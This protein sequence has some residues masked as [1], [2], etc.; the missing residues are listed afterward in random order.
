MNIWEW[1]LWILPF[2]LQSVV[3]AVDEGYF[4]KKRGVQTLEQVGH[5]L[6]TFTVLV[7]FLILIFLRPEGGNLKIYLFFVVL[8]CLSVTKDEWIHA[9]C[10]QPAEHWVHAVLFVLHPIVLGCAGML[11]WQ[12]SL[13]ANA[14]IGVQATLVGGIFLM[15]SLQAGL[16]WLQKV[17][18]G[19]KSGP[20]IEHACYSLLGDR[21]YTAF[22]DPVALLRAEAA[23]KNPW[24]HETM[25]RKLGTRSLQ[26]LDIGC[27]AGFL[28]N[29]LALW[30]NQ[31]TGVDLSESAL[32]VARKF[33]TTKTV[34]YRQ[35]DAYALPFEDQ[36]FDVVCAMDFLE[37]V[38][39]PDQVVAE[40]SRVL[41]PGG[42][43]FFHTFN[44]TWLSW[45]LAIQAVKWLVKNTPK[46]L[47][48][49]GLFIKPMELRKILLGAGLV[50]Q[51]VRGVKP[52][53]FK[54]S[55]LRSLFTRSVPVDF[56]FAFT[57]CQKVGYAGYA[58][59]QV[60]T[61]FN[62]SLGSV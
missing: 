22:D 62:Q 14:V 20:G 1:L 32:E 47:H 53:L 39:R 31:V 50:T 2:G 60:P 54:K 52:L 45:V 55:V 56:E 12:N 58:V 46:N 33:D 17:V 18:K 48:L 21:W 26:V 40:V 13:E 35:A 49:Y 28:S 11:W 10:C 34:Q 37:H 23:L 15:L 3:F 36:A 30:K 57:R 44:R 51:E 5:A 16:Q 4:H 42:L 41:R 61:D 7:C 27:G 19:Q 43:F 25:R 8:S 9:R 38:Q 6:D 24:I 59:R 29:S